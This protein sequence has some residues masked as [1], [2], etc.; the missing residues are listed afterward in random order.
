MANH[1]LKS[2]KENDGEILPQTNKEILEHLSAIEHDQWCLWSQEVT[3]DID[4]MSESVLDLLGIIDSLK[5]Y[6]RVPGD[7]ESK[8]DL[9]HQRLVKI[10]Q[11]LL[12]WERLWQCTYAKLS[13]EEKSQDR[14]WA[15][16]VLDLIEDIANN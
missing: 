4:G 14:V 7:T 10:K 1:L 9:A 11:K 2:K 8:V 6:H 3:R 16:K 5:K 13:E 12:R 15:N